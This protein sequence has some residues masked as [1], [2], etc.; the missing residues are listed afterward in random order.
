MNFDIEKRNT[1]FV[2]AAVAMGDDKVM[3]NGI[4]PQKK[5]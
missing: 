4:P 3:K 1:T 2:V 5:N